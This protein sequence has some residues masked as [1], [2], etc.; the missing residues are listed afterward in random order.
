ML[1]P[2]HKG[3]QMIELR[4]MQLLSALA[5]HRHFAKAAEECGISQPAFSMRIRKFED[6][7][8]VTIVR[9]GNRFQGLTGEGELLVARARIIL[10]EVR[11]LEQEFKAAQ[12]EVVG[13]L[14]LGVVPTAIAFAARLAVHLHSTYPRIVMRIVSA[15][16]LA[17]QQRLEEGT[18]DAGLTYGDSIGTDQV[19]LETLYEESYV[20]LAPRAMVPDG[21]TGITGITWAEAAELPLSLL[22]PGMQNRRILDRMFADL[23]LTPRVISETN[24]FTA[25]MVMAREGLAATIVPQVLI[26][27]LGDLDGA[28][29]L[30]LCAPELCKPICLATPERTMEMPVVRAL[31]EISRQV[32]DKK[33]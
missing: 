18:I 5:R 28:V 13:T 16:S 21:I 17:I 32:R 20:L 25:S 3:H 12:G 26:A 9:R 14:V 8:G 2:N 31:K 29:V 1:G 4:D 10:D 19:A 23:C 22:E 24:G 15:S 30:P 33:N 27:A 11:A 6:R 7:L